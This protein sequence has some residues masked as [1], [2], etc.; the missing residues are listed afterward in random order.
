MMTVLLRFVALALLSGGV[1]GGCAPPPTPVPSIAKKLAGEWKLA[2][3][4]RT[5]LSMT[6]DG[7]ASGRFTMTVYP[8]IP[9]VFRGRWTVE[10]RV[11]TLQIEEFP[12]MTDWAT[13]LSGEKPPSRFVEEVVRLTDTELLLRTPGA[14]PIEERYQRVR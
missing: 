5:T 4:S 1:L 6:T 3:K 8:L 10:G 12:A 7:P 13:A 2:D 14:N 9:M 11:L